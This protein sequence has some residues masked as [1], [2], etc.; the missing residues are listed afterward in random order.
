M[1]NPC[2]ILLYP[3]AC[4]GN[5]AVHLR[6]VAYPFVFCMFFEFKLENG[7]ACVLIGAFCRKVFENDAVAVFYE[8]DLFSG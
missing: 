5:A 8:I 3:V 7:Y 1:R 6:V 2:G 4:E